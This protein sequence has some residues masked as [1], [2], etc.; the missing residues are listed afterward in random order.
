MICVGDA[1]IDKEEDHVIVNEIDDLVA[2]V[3][4]VRDDENTGFKVDVISRIFQDDIS[5]NLLGNPFQKA[6]TLQFSEEGG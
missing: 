3:D 4:H 5:Q 2:I 6:L 1:P